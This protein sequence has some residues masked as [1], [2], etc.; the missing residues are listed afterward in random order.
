MKCQSCFFLFFF[1]KIRKLFQ[2]VVCWNFYPAPYALR[3]NLGFSFTPNIESWTPNLVVGTSIFQRSLAK[4]HWRRDSCFQNPSENSGNWQCWWCF[5]RSYIF[6]CT[7]M[8][9]DHWVEK[10]PYLGL[11]FF[12]A[13]RK[14]ACSNMLKI[15]PPKN[16]NF[17][18]KNCDIFHISAKNIDCGTR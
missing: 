16:E 15:L 1:G 9:A 11:F 14:H 2:N 12:F 3:W 8:T 7:C 18:L 13:F 6:I 4:L 5:V 10:M 17:Q